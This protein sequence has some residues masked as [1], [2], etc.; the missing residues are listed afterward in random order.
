MCKICFKL[1]KVQALNAYIS[2]CYIF[3]EFRSQ[4]IQL[5]EAV[6]HVPGLLLKDLLDEELLKSKDERDAL[7]KQFSNTLDDLLKKQ[8]L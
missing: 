5:E 6:S 4:L 7:S 2:H 3:V 1:S 8:V